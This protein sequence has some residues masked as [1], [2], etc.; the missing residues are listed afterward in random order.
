MGP[1][2]SVLK[3]MAQAL[4]V[5]TLG[6]LLSVQSF[7]HCVFAEFALFEAIQ[8]SHAVVYGCSFQPVS[9]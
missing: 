8:W 6:L 1:V 2:H 7:I 5:G 9:D 4:Q 3:A